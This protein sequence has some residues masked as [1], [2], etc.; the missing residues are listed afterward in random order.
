M[1]GGHSGFMSPAPSDR[2]DEAIETPFM[3]EATEKNAD[4]VVKKPLME[5]SKETNADSFVTTTL[6][7]RSMDTNES[8]DQG[9]VYDALKTLVI[10]SPLSYVVKLAVKENWKER[11]RNKKEF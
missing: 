3:A 9:T 7:A 10:N 11:Q 1:T 8:V 2:E 5:E 6:I 4:G